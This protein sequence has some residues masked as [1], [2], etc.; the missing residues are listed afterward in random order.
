MNGMK[1][2]STDRW[3]SAIAAIGFLGSVAYGQAAKLDDAIRLRFWENPEFVKRFMGTYG[4]NTE[5]EPRF[6][7]P[8]EQMAFR[9]LGDMIRE[10]PEA[11]KGRLKKMITPTSSAVLP[12]TLGA[13][14]FQE[15]DAAQAIEQFELALSKFPD[16]RRAH[17]NMGFALAQEGRYREASKSLTKA[18][19]LG[20]VDASIYGLLGYS[21][22]N[23]GKKLSAE[24]AYL[25]A[26][27]LDPDNQ[28]W[29]LG[30]IKSYI[31][32]ANY[33]QA[34]A[35]LDEILSQN[36]DSANLWSLQANVYLQMEDNEN[37]AIN[38]EMLRRM[39]KATL[40]NLML[41]G[42]IYMMDDALGLALPVYLEAIEK[43]GV[44]DIR[45]SLRAAEILVSR[46]AWTEANQMFAKIQ[47]RH[48][49][50]VSDDEE[51]KLLRLESRVAIAN[52]EG[53]KALAVL[54]QIIS[55]NPLD[56]EALLM[57]GEFYSQEGESEKAVFRY[58]MAAKLA[59]FEADAWLKHA[60]LLV[61]QQDYNEALEL[62]RKAQKM[63]P[64]DNVQKYLEAV[65]RVARASAG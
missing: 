62:L 16:F 60:Q 22:I 24:G 57:A 5:I 11:A 33:S 7:T 38:F 51:A 28:D 35:L 55:K 31:A 27:L 4:V 36:P 10:N 25:N 20:A 15:G 40:P 8:E 63:T 34:I 30:L 50:A 65:E 13:I 1:C 53:E 17:R 32:R 59:G 14:F 23:D 42:D 39:G 47:Q 26:L 6:E 12:F 9:E 18:L 2:F 41:L 48:E 44:N 64:R 54:E 19:N 37:A 21:Y 45:R 58:E 43:D 49:G 29:K 61:R 3:L 52:G 56:G 46:G